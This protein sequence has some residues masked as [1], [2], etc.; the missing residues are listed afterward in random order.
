[1]KKLTLIAMLLVTALC[2]GCGTLTRNLKLSLLH[3][4][5]D[6]S[7]TLLMQG[8]LVTPEAI[9][10]VVPQIREVLA[11]NDVIEDIIADL[12]AKVPACPILDT[13]I[14]ALKSELYSL[15]ASLTGMRLWRIEEIL[16]AFEGRA[17]RWRR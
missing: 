16:A 8:G 5:A 15:K 6:V 13:V 2:A 10:E 9:L 1:M 7:A 12:E 17:E 14:A 3:G 11:D 4:S